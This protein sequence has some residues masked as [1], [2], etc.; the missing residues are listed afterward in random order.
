MNKR[1]ITALI[2]ASGLFAASVASADIIGTGAPGAPTDSSP[3]LM[4]SLIDI[5][6][7]GAP[8]GDNGGSGSDNGGN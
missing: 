2:L 6:G 4:Q 3:T 7:T 5:I 8:G 1:A